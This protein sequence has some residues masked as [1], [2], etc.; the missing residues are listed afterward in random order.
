MVR[1]TDRHTKDAKNYREISNTLKTA[2]TQNMAYRDALKQVKA[3]SDIEKQTSATTADDNQIAPTVEK[4]SVETQTEQE[5]A[6]QT[7]ATSACPFTEEEMEK[8]LQSTAAVLI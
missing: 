8:L 7:E 5:Q 3:A 2:A 6:V 4:R 1:D